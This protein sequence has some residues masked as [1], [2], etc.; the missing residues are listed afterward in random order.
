M[1]CGK[2]INKGNYSIRQMSVK[3]EISYE[4]LRAILNGERKDISVSTLLK[5][6]ANTG[7]A[8]NNLLD[9]EA[10]TIKAIEVV[11]KC[12]E[13]SYLFFQK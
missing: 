2:K 10:E 8:I 13:N 6:C 1:S 5:I 12:G 9:V 11:V 4:N 7:M 3:C